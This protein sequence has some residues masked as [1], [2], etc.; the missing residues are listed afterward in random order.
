[1]KALHTLALG[2]ALA[3]GTAAP[4]HAAEPDATALT[5]GS[6]TRGEI[7]SRTALNYRDGSRSQLYRVNLREGQVVSFQANGALRAKLSAFSEGELLGTSAEGSENPTLVVRAKRSGAHTLAVSGLDAD[8]FGPYTLTSKAIEA[9]NGETL[10]VGA[11]ISDWIDAER[12]LPLQVDTPGLYTIDML[13]DDFDTVLQLEGQGVSISNDDG[14]DGSN[15]RISMMLQPGR[16]TLTAKGYG[17]SVN[18]MYQLRVATRELPA[19]VMTSG[20]PIAVDSNVTG[21]YQ[22]TPQRFT[23]TL[24]ARR[25]V[26]IDMGSS[27]IDSMLT[28]TGNGVQ[29]NDDDG[30]DGLNSRIVMLLESGSY[31]L[32][33]GTASEGA[34]LFTLA[35]A[36]SDVPSGVGGGALAVGRSTEATLLPGM[37]DR[38]TV[39]VR[40]AGD[41]TIDMRADDLDSH[42]RLLRGTEEVA[43]DD[44]GGDGLNSRIQRR[45]ESGDYVI[46]ATSVGSG[47]TGRYTIGIDRR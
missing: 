31:T 13:S 16:Y 36:A 8:A 43:S 11:S 1:M 26:R 30:G 24:P 9:Y 23:F 35:L 7:T 37:T 10:T 17:S 12:R 19:G 27:E 22:G 45:L 44:D 21:L 5:L 34:G 38:Y 2:I 32:E 39:S 41:Y 40:S 47:S 46:E 6:D 14:G 4:L 42:L 28:L 20:G 33:A 15:A 3:I 18:G 25:L 29:K